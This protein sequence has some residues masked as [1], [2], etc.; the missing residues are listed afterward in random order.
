MS[1][2]PRQSVAAA[3][4]LLDMLATHDAASD[5]VNLAAT[6]VAAM[7]LQE[8]GA[9]TATQAEDGAVAVNLNALLGAFGSSPRS[10][11]MLSQRST[12]ACRASR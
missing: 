10:R 12:T 7:R 3:H 2:M 11:P 6:G 1:E 4:V 8:G 5:E 9:V